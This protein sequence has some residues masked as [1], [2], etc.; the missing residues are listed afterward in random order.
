MRT[1]FFKDGPIIL[2]RPSD[3]RD[4]DFALTMLKQIFT[5]R[6]IQTSVKRHE[7]FVSCSER[8]RQ[9]KRAATAKWRHKQKKL[10]T[11]I[12]RKENFGQKS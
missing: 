1:P 10:K 7:S 3:V 5:T 8:R 12:K 2:S 11:L 9:E 4:L 6:G